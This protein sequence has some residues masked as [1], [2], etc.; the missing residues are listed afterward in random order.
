LTS[1]I[2]IDLITYLQTQN[3]DNTIEIVSVGS[4]TPIQFNDF[5]ILD[6]WTVQIT[7]QVPN[8]QTVC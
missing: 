6:G 2:L 8:E 5:N 1:S 7:I 3:N 4:L